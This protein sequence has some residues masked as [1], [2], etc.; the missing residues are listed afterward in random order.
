MVA[1][2]APPRG[3][4]TGAMPDLKARRRRPEPPHPKIVIM[5]DQSS[6]PYIKYCQYHNRVWS[7]KT[8]TWK[9]VP[10]DF[11]AELRHADLPVDLIEWPCSRC[12]K[13]RGQ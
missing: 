3:I 5:A 11:I 13:Q 7:P 4:P 2:Q 12:G 8:R 10:A 6:I 9:V 1:A